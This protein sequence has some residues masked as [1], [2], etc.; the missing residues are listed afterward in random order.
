MNDLIEGLFEGVYQSPLGTIKIV[1]NSVGIL[2]IQFDK[3][4]VKNKANSLVKEAIIQ[5]TQY[6]QNERKIFELPLI[7]QGTSFQKKVWDRLQE[8]P[9]GKTTSYSNLA[10][11][12]NNPLA[13]RAVGAANRVNRHAIV[14]PCHRVIGSSGKLTGY[15]GGL[16][17]KSALLSLENCQY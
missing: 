7:Y 10:E 11:S 5:L 6:F 16:D 4:P 13:A 17:R 3:D 2:S 14:I 12:I 15:A 1:A 9:Y 8:I